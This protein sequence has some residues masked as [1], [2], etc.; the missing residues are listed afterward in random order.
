LLNSPIT[1]F[2]LNNMVKIEQ[3]DRRTI[4]VSLQI[5]KEQIRVPKITERNQ[6]IKDQVIKRTEEMLRLEDV[7]LDNLIDFTN[8]MMQKFDSVSVKENNLVLCKDKKGKKLKIKSNIDL[9]EKA[10]ADKYKSYELEFEHEQIKLPE[11]KSLPIIDFEKQKLLKE[12]IDDLVFALYFN[13][14]LTKVELKYAADIKK[15]CQ[16]NSFYKLVN[17]IP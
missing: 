3:E 5:I 1:N 9:V 2:L 16:K 15:L 8:V 7:I 12:Y 6:F 13:I 11:L 14:P 10:I 4:L 17:E